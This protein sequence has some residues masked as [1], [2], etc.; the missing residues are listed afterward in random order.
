MN[1]KQGTI[2]A[3]E[4]KN[5]FFGGSFKMPALSVAEFRYVLALL[6]QEGV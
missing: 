1:H 4:I 2:I 5:A 3:R 6:N